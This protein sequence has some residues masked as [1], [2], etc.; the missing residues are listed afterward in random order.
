MLWWYFTGKK[1]EKDGS[2]DVYLSGG[3][4]KWRE[5]SFFSNGITNV[6]SLIPAPECGGYCEKT[7]H[8]KTV[9]FVNCMWEATL[10]FS[11]DFHLGSIA[12]L[13][14]SEK[15]LTGVSLESMLN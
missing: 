14:L 3:W 2:M 13:S 1:G 4:C 6:I 8:E 12:L 7:K 9:I 11:Y 10:V 15:L 5:I